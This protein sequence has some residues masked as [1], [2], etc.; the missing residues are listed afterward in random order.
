MFMNFE[1]DNVLRNIKILELDAPKEALNA[2]SKL[3]M[4]I[5]VNAKR[6]LASNGSIATGA[7]RTSGSVHKYDLNINL[8]KNE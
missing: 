1:K 8:H 6:R 7:L 3:A 5:L 4:N 2:L